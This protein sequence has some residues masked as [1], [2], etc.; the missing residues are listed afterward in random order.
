[1]TLS[2]IALN[3]ARFSGMTFDRMTCRVTRRLEKIAQILEKVAQR[4][5]KPKNGTL[6]PS[7]LY[8]YQ[9]QIIFSSKNLLAL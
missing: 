8:K 1:M 9:Q 3:R 2:R 7:E 5:T 4:V 6:P